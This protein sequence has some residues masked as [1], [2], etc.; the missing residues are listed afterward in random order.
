MRRKPGRHNE[1]RRTR[2][3]A[4]SLPVLPDRRLMEEHLTAVRRLVEGREFGSL[5]ELNAYLQEALAD[6]GGQRHRPR[7]GRRWSKPRR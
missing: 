2:G 4:A 6:G 3:S 1:R 5:D 7:R